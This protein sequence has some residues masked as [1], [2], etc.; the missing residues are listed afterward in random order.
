M[1][2]GE[3][4]YRPE[5]PMPELIDTIRR[6]LESQRL[7]ERLLCRYLADLSDRV[8]ARGVDTGG[9]YADIYQAARCLFG[10]GVR[11]TRERVRVGRALRGLPRIEEALLDGR[12]AYSRVREITRVARP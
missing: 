9:E 2:R 4:T 8:D 5:L 7:A 12:L 11:R 3:S 1:N 10:M 6:L